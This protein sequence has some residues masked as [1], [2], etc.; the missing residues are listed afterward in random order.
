MSEHGPT[1]GP[2][3]PASAYQRPT[4][5]R[6]TERV[7]FSLVDDDLTTGIVLATLNAGDVVVE[8]YLH[9]LEEPGLGN[10]DFGLFA[11]SAD[12]D[13]LLNGGSASYDEDTG[14]DVEVISYITDGPSPIKTDGTKVVIAYGDDVD[15]P[16]TAGRFEAWLLVSYA[17]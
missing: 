10:H 9:G 1:P 8:F 7:S 14:T 11:G 12:G 15:E 6:Q 13:R 4:G 16:E 5:T 3:D 17:P 2:N